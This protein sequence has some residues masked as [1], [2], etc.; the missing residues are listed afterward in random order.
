MH[1]TQSRTE[2]EKIDHDA[3]D[4]NKDPMTQPRANARWQQTVIPGHISGEI[5]SSAHANDRSRVA[6]PHISSIRTKTFIMQTA[7]DTPQSSSARAAVLGGRFRRDHSQKTQSAILQVC[8]VN[9][10]LPSQRRGIGD[11]FQT[12]RYRVGKTSRV[13][14]VSKFKVLEIDC[15][16]EPGPKIGVAQMPELF[17]QFA[18]SGRGR[19]NQEQGATFLGCFQKGLPKPQIL[20]K[21]GSGPR[22][23]IDQVHE[24]LK[25]VIQTFS[26]RAGRPKKPFHGLR[27]RLIPLEVLGFEPGS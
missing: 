3:D 22:I 10:I 25:R 21:G 5:G 24:R 1:Q 8:G 14:G 13:G 15:R 4:K 12:H 17:H 9:A 27:Q 19:I 11:C 7:I 6:K 23:G 2:T 16:R 20:C 26:R 18:I